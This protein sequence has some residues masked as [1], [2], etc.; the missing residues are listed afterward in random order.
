MTA[1]ADST[2]YGSKPWLARYAPGQ[3]SS[4]TVEF[5]SALDMFRAAVARDPDGEIIRYFDGRITLRELDALT[6]AF[7]A[8]ITDAGFSPGERVAVYLQNVPQFLVSMLAAWKAGGIMVS[9]NPMSRERE[10]QH[11]LNDS[12]AV[13]VGRQRYSIGREPTGRLFGSCRE[14]RRPALCCQPHGRLAGANRPLSVEE[15]SPWLCDR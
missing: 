5:D 15:G 8:G 6:D 3:P 7:A 11:L 1:A 10:L 4:I 14:G 12:G 2:I 13:V 9:V